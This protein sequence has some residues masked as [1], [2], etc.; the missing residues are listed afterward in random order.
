MNN[1]YKIL[2]GVNID[3]VATIRQARGTAY[4][5]IIEA[6]FIAQEGGADGITVHLRE[7]RR[8]IQDDDVIQLKE[9]IKLPLNFEMAVTPAM[10]DF[11]LSVSPQHACF[12]PEKREE[13]TTEGG[14][15]VIANMQAIQEACEQLQ[16]KGTEVSLFIDPSP[17][18]IL[19][20]VQSGAKA[21]ELHTGQYAEANSESEQY[22]ELN[23]LTLAAH[24]AH[25][26]GLIVNAGHG[27]HYENVKPIA[28]IHHMHELNIGHSIVAKALMIGMHDAIFQMKQLI[29]EAV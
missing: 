4:P 15:D 19:A 14:L 10:V 21:I 6:A 25:E 1:K 18:Q 26:A 3:H 2:L 16:K 7:D 27:L 12:V 17:E 23:R 13:L 9:K 28:A 5:S 29:K 11:A 8:H 22:E 24:T 20:A